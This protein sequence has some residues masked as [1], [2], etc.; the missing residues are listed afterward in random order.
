MRLPF[1]YVQFMTELMAPTPYPRQ[2]NF[3]PPR[4][5]PLRKPIS[6]STVGILTSAG[7][8]HRADPF[9]P[10][11]MILVTVLSMPKLR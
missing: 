11:P 4:L 9:W 10:K 2:P 7:V 8:Q 3:A 6:Q 1:S 5:T